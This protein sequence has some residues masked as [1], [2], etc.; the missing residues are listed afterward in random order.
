MWNPIQ[1]PVLYGFR[2]GTGKK[3]DPKIGFQN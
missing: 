1:D 3:L 2:T